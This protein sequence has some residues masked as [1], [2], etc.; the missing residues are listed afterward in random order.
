V[1]P[2]TDEVIEQI[3]DLRHNKNLATGD[4]CIY[5]CVACYVRDLDGKESLF[6]TKDRDFEPAGAMLLTHKC[7]LITSFGAAFGAIRGHTAH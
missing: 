7:R 6:V 1:I 2:V 4:A 5:A 3:T